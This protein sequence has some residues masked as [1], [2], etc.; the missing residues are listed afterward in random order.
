MSR[1]IDF[2]N[3]SNVINFDFPTSAKQYIH[4]A[5]RTAR[6]DN[7]G[8]VINLMIGQEERDCLD[9]VTEVTG[10]SVDRFKFKMEQVEGLRFVPIS[11]NEFNRKIRGRASDALDKCSKRAI[12][13]GRVAEIKQA[14]LNSKKLQVRF[15]LI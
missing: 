14:I 6:G 4:R 8:R 1:G 5:G 15:T 3:V 13:D 9:K 7:K 2:Q 12:R 10:I 11:N